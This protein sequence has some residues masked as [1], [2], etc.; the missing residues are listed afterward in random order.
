MGRESVRSVYSTAASILV[1][2]LLSAY[3]LYTIT[4]T[5]QPMAQSFHTTVS[6][7]ALAITLSWIGGA[8][9][10]LLFGVYSDYS[11]RRGALLISIL[12]FSVATL[13]VYFAVALWE[14]YVLW[15]IV[16][17]GVNGENGVSYT[18]VAELRLSGRRGTVGGLMQG[19][20]AVG[21]LLG[22]LTAS[23]ILPRGPSAWR[24][25]FLASGAAS[26]AS[27]AP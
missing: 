6:S 8:A 9:G 26:L 14:L 7:V 1:P 24:L 12:V 10:G 11:T 5:L 16:G 25:M 2:F 18:L 19:L 20:Y 17:L 13:L 22:A 3:A 4:F 23:L 21:T 27:L 15:F